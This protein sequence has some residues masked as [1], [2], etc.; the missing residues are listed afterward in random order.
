VNATRATPSPFA[1][2][3]FAD[4]LWAIAATGL[5][6]D[7]PPELKMTSAV[8]LVDV[9][10][11]DS[12]EGSEMWCILYRHRSVGNGKPVVG[13]F[14]DRRPPAP[15]DP[16]RIAIYSS[17]EEFW[18]FEIEE[19]PGMEL[20]GVTPDAAG[21]LWRQAPPPPNEDDIVDRIIAER[22]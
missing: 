1:D 19:P 18:Q 17:A 9:R 4:R 16:T 15:D 21:I 13:L 5:E 7:F 20:H 11:V 22:R 3:D 2:E 10:S 12:A 8:R 14:V 6:P